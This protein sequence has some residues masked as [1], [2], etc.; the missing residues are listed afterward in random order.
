MP[1]FNISV[2]I[3]APTLDDAINVIESALADLQDTDETQ[4]E[5]WGFDWSFDVK[6]HYDN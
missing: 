1:R 4:V 3:E 5:L 2:L 6:K